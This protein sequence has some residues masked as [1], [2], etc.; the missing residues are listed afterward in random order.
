MDATP[1]CAS[2]SLRALE[3]SRSWLTDIAGRVAAS[4][5]GDARRAGEG[6][7]A[8]RAGDAGGVRAGDG[9]ALAGGGV[10][11]GDGVR[12][13]GGVELHL[14]TVTGTVMRAVVAGVLPVVGLALPTD[15]DCAPFPRCRGPGLGGLRPLRMAPKPRCS[16][17][18]ARY[19]PAARRTWSC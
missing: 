16:Q 18:S 4:F 15:M 14:F 3:E 9:S 12:A 11:G 17:A 19:A 8:R 2:A 7:T 10:R 1:S 13:G 6:D 5:V